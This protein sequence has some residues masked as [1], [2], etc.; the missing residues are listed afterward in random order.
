MEEIAANYADAEDLTEQL[1]NLDISDK[2]HGQGES[3]IQRRKGKK[4][5]KKGKGKAKGRGQGKKKPVVTFVP[6]V[7]ADKKDTKGKERRGKGYFFPNFSG[8]PS[9]ERDDDEGEGEDDDGE[10]RETVMNPY[11]GKPYTRR[12]FS[13]LK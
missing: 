4:K 8:D 3:Q 6:P 11:N 1:R 12:Y 10:H 7:Y 5:G 9:H 2:S 13:L